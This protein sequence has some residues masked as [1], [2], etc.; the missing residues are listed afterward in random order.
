MKKKIINVLF[1]GVLVFLVAI[2]VTAATYLYNAN[3]VSY[4]NTK[5]GLSSTDVQSV[6][7]ELYTK[8]NASTTTCPSGHTC[9]DKTNIKCQRATTL[10][11]EPC[12]NSI[13]SNYCQS[14]G[15]ALNGTITYGNE[16]TTTGVLTTGDAFDCDINGDGTFDAATERFYYISDYFDTNT[17]TFNDKVAVLVYYSNTDDGVESTSNEAYAT[18]ADAQAIGTCTS[19]NGCN[20]YGPVTAISELPTTTQWGNISLY[21]NT[22]QILA[23][24]NATSTSGGT[25]PTAFDYSGYGARLLT[26]QELN[27]GCYDYYNLSVES[28]KGLNTNC[29]FLYERTKYANSSYATYGSWLETP[30][31]SSTATVY[32]WDSDIRRAGTLST[33]YTYSD[34]VRPVIEILKSEILY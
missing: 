34:G 18:V 9:T 22:R 13:T 4:D 5:S 21:K 14:D 11:T 20:W 17:K 7:S 19:S 28:T 15:Y 16:T 27:H 33:L 24:N 30:S 3:E 2:S 10:H 29:R 12:T 1:I 8:C 32:R 25:L 6:M 26:Y 31:A 23:Q